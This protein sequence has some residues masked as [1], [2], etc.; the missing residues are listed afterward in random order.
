VASNPGCLT[1]LNDMGFVGPLN[2]AHLATA[3]SHVVALAGTVAVNVQR[4]NANAKGALEIFMPVLPYF[5]FDLRSSRR[6]SKK[7]ESVFNK[8]HLG[9]GFTP[10]YL[11]NQLIAFRRRRKYPPMNYVLE[12][13]PEPAQTACDGRDRRFVKPRKA[14]MPSFS[15]L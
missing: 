11:Y 10:R 5:R 1:L 4:P 2:L 14:D 13:L 9:R 7:E 12:F 6:H 15:K 8:T 3:S